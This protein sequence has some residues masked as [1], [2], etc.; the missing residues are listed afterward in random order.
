MG[1]SKARTAAARFPAAAPGEFKAP[2]EPA[3]FDGPATGICCASTMSASTTRLQF[4][5]GHEPD[6]ITEAQGPLGGWERPSRRFAT[7]A[8][9]R[10]RRGATSPIRS[11]PSPRASAVGRGGPIALQ[12]RRTAR[13]G[14][15]G[16]PRTPTACAAQALFA[17]GPALSP[18]PQRR[19]P[20]PRGEA[21]RS[22]RGLSAAQDGAGLRLIISLEREIDTDPDL[23]GVDPGLNGAAAR[24]AAA[25]WPCHR[26]PAPRD[27]S[28]GMRHARRRRGCRARARS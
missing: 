27:P 26:P 15:S 17:A 13:A 18:R 14:G 5:R 10:R 24:P 19:R 9:T 1:G 28:V 20:Q 11:T 12:P 6:E 25:R 4:F 22:D 16:W 8:P 23:A 2:V 21:R 7:R 3:N